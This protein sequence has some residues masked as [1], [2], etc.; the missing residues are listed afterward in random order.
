MNDRDTRLRE[1]REAA[2]RTAEEDREKYG[3]LPDS[4]MRAIAGL[5][6]SHYAGAAASCDAEEA[7][8]GRHCH[9]EVGNGE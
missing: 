4:V 2:R 6:R 7:M 3:P 5:L 9:L 1:I 8:K